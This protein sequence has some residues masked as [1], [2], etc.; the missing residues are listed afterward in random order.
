MLAMHRLNL[1]RQGDELGQSATM[2]IVVAGFD[3]ADQFIAVHRSWRG[4]LPGAGT[5]LLQRALKLVGI[6]SA[7][8]R[9]AIKGEIAVAAEVDL[10]LAENGGGARQRS[11]YVADGAFP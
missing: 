1:A 6:D 8:V 5:K 3:V 9:S 2:R 4:Y 10:E 7:P 11:G